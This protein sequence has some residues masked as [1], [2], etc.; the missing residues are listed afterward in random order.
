L[1]SELAKYYASCT[2]DP[3]PS[4]TYLIVGEDQLAPEDQDEDLSMDVDDSRHLNDDIDEEYTGGEDVPQTKFLL[5]TESEFEGILH[6][7]TC[8]TAKCAFTPD[9]KSTFRRIS[10]IHVYSLSPSLIRVRTHSEPVEFMFHV[11][12]FSR[13]QAYSVYQ[14]KVFEILMAAKMARRWLLLSGES[15]ARRFRLVLFVATIF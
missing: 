11:L 8:H 9:A 14:Q 4:A 2:Q 7:T 15:L 10:A 1:D 13:I 5:V 6:A 12:I 3:A